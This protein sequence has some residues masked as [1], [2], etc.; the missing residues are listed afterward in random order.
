MIREYWIP[1]RSKWEGE[2]KVNKPLPDGSLVVSNRNGFWLTKQ[3]FNNLSTLLPYKK[4]REELKG[5]LPERTESS[6]RWG[7]VIQETEIHGHSL[8]DFVIS[9]VQL[10]RLT[11]AAIR[12]TWIWKLD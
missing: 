2:A 6:Q 12:L 4:S 7:S 10:L 3:I 1:V 9:M 8:E 11:W 5:K